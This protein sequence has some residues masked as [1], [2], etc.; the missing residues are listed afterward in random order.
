MNLPKLTHDIHEL[1]YIIEG[2]TIHERFLELFDSIPL[3]FHFIFIIFTF[4]LIK[5]IISLNNLRYRGA[6]TSLSRKNPIIAILLTV[7]TLYISLWVSTSTAKISSGEIFSQAKELGT[8]GEYFNISVMA[9]IPII[10]VENTI[11]LSYLLIEKVLN[12]KDGKVSLGPEEIIKKLKFLQENQT[13][14]PELMALHR[15][16]LDFCLSKALMGDPKN[17]KML[18]KEGL[19][20]IVSNGKS[21]SYWDSQFQKMKAKTSQTC[22][23]LKEKINLK[24]IEVYQINQ[25][26]L[27]L[28]TKNLL[29]QHGY[30]Q[31]KS[32][33]LAISIILSESLGQASR[34]ELVRE[35]TEVEGF[36]GVLQYAMKLTSFDIFSNGMASSAKSANKFSDFLKRQ[37]HIVGFFTLFLIIIFPFLGPLVMWK[38]VKVLKFWF[39]SYFICRMSTVLLHFVWLIQK[40]LMLDY[41]VSDAMKIMGDSLSMQSAQYI[42]AEFQYS[43]GVNNLFQI[44]L[45]LGTSLFVG[46]KFLQSFDGNS[47]NDD[48]PREVSDVATKT[49]STASKVI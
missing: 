31:T 6:G 38:G 46:K 37:P 4:N 1:R 20:A 40:R 14:S 9:Y 41:S 16:F 10:I 27:N 21:S 18:Q 15:E 3:A 17:Q 47:E 36:G 19:D 42:S 35:G 13:K 45:G 30:D 48:A 11:K 25:S 43:A 7:F 28:L 49:V 22:S 23:D 8:R 5:R 33:N 34:G 29:P 26:D 32:R 39:L 2:L 24:A 12:V 44:A